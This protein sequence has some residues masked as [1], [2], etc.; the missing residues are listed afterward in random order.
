[1][2][3]CRRKADEDVAGLD[4]FACNDFF[5]VD[6]ADAE[7]GQVVIV[8][9]IEASHFSRF[10]AEKGAARFLAGIGDAFYD[11]RYLYGIQLAYGDVVQEEQ[12][13]CPLDENIV[14]GHGYT[15][16]ADRIM[17]VHHDSQAQLRAYAVGTAY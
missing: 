1:M 17:L 2:D 3:A 12:R 11:R 14:N 7:A 6:D 4:R 8:L 9:R 15:V 5:T 13:L 10:A 16:L